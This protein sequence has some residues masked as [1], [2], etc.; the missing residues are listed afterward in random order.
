MLKGL[1]Q[2]RDDISSRGQGYR[3]EGGVPELDVRSGEVALIHFLTDQHDIIEARFHRVPETT[4]KG[5]IVTHERFCKA[6]MGERCPFCGHSS[7]DI[8]KRTLRWFAWVYAYAILTPNPIPNIPNPKQVLRGTRTL[9]VWELG[10]SAVLRKGEGNNKYIVQQ[11]LS[12]TERYNTLCD[13]IYE[14]ER[15][16]ST[17]NDTTYMLAPLPDLVPKPEVGS[18]QSLEEIVVKELALSPVPLRQQPKPKDSA[19]AGDRT[20]QLMSLLQGMTGR[21]PEL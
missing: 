18:L 11:L 13:R 2:I 7:E 10:Q 9:N 4:P 15:T 12:H 21:K 6:E 20:S 19:P 1:S 17:R 8:R 3:P 14:L 16:G 5:T